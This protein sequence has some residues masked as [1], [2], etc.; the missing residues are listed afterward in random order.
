MPADAAAAP[1][2]VSEEP[3]SERGHWET[4]KARAQATIREPGDLP[5][6][7]SPNHRAGLPGGTDFS[8]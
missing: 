2:T 1:A 4:G 3:A 5:S 7:S 8:V 6:A